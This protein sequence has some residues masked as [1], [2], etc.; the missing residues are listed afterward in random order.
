MERQRRE[1]SIT[2]DQ[3]K[4]AT[5]DFRALA[6]VVSSCWARGP[7]KILPDV[8]PPSLELQ[9]AH[10][11]QEEWNQADGAPVFGDNGPLWHFRPSSANL[12]PQHP[13][14]TSITKTKVNSLH[15]HPAVSPLVESFLRPNVLK[16]RSF[17]RGGPASFEL[18]NSREKV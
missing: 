8:P 2:L 10:K 9:G 7:C 14:P 4:C 16:S 6:S 11:I 15:L 17:P 12:T 3:L 5:R 1:R 18:G 13:T